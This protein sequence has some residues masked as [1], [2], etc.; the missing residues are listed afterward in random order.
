VTMKNNLLSYVLLAAIGCIVVAMLF[1]LAPAQSSN[2]AVKTN[3]PDF[4]CGYEG[5]VVSGFSKG[6]P[7]CT[8][9]AGFIVPDL[10]CEDAH[11]EPQVLVG[12][13]D[14][15]PVCKAIHFDWDQNLQTNVYS[16]EHAIHLQVRYIPNQ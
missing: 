15:K 6:K 14:G 7:V 2:G 5:Q 12:I 11:Y 10:K 16:Y 8:M 4:K 3:I 13:R 9:P 1:Q